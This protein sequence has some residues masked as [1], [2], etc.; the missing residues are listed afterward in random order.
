MSKDRTRMVQKND[1]LFV[2]DFGLR[3]PVIQKIFQTKIRPTSTVAHVNNPFWT[4][5]HDKTPEELV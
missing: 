1:L 2:D 5:K 4:Q 3:S